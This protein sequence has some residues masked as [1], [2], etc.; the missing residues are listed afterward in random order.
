[1][2]ITKFW[3]VS[4]VQEIWIAKHMLDGINNVAENLGQLK[5]GDHMNQLNVKPSMSITF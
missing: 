2:H 5:S 1:M 3:K 4:G